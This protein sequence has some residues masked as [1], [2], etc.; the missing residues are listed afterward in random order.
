MAQPAKVQILSAAAAP[1]VAPPDTLTPVKRTY[2]E[3]I[4]LMRQQA[5]RT[6]A[7]F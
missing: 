1:Q 2:T 6:A 3:A 4:A 7:Q 5:D